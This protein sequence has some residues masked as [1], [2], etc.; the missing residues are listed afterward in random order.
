MPAPQ[1]LGR[2]R[3]V[4]PLRGIKQHVDDAI[5]STVSGSQGADVD[6]QAPG[7]RRTHRMR[8]EGFALDFAGLEHIVGQHTQ[9]RSRVWEPY[10]NAK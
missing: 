10:L 1:A 9:A 4:M 7:K 8:V 5:S 3:M 6:T 2:Q